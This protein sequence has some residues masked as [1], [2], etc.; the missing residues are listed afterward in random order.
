MDVCDVQKFYTFKL[1][2]PVFCPR[3]VVKLSVKFSRELNRLLIHFPLFSLFS[4]QV[5]SRDHAPGIV[6]CD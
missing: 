1:L 6:H 2:K 5:P 3:T 4:G